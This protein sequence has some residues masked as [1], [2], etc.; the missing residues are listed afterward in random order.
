MQ[1]GR[2][3]HTTIDGRDQILQ[4]AEADK[5]LTADNYTAVSNL[6]QPEIREFPEDYA[7][8]YTSVTP[9]FE[10]STGRMFYKNNTLIAK[11]T[12]LELFSFL[13]VEEV[14]KLLNRAKERTNLFNR[15]VK[16]SQNDGVALC[17][18]LPEVIL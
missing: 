2:I 18:P 16:T 17:N 12:P 13:K 10:E 1:I 14:A 9:E 11:F 4:T 5:L 3:I 6:T 8:T 15:M 7:V